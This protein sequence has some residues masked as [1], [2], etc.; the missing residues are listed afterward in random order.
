MT[1]TFV[2][3]E[4]GLTASGWSRTTAF[5]YYAIFVKPAVVHSAIK[6]MKHRVFK[7]A[8]F[9]APEPWPPVPRPRQRSR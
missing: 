3:E 6:R 7:P 5:G 8:Y 9:G 4:T 1:L 2:L